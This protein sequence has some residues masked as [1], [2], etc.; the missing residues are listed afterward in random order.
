MPGAP[1]PRR[2]PMQGVARAVNRGQ[3]GMAGGRYSGLSKVRRNRPESRETPD[4]AG[5]HYYGA[6]N[7]G[8]GGLAGEFLD[9]GDN[10]FLPEA[11]PTDDFAN[12]AA[13]TWTLGAGEFTAQTGG[14]WALWAA[15][16]IT[17]CDPS[18][19]LTLKL[20]VSSIGTVEIP[21]LNN[22]GDV[23][24]ATQIGP[25]PAYPDTTTFTVKVNYAG[26]S[27]PT[28][29]GGQASFWPTGLFPEVG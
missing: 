29:V 3:G 18:D 23:R 13:A 8:I 20:T 4:P 11:T 5:L 25:C 19:L 21:L 24:G 2:E 10:F 16:S 27:S 28:W 7:V 1:Y 9:S 22:G 17:D 6:M 12:G 15:V 26:F 14:Y